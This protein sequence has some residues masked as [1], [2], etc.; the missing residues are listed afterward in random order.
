MGRNEI[1]N[2]SLFKRRDDCEDMR[3]NWFLCYGHA[4]VSDKVS[5]I[6]SKV[7]IICVERL[8]LVVKLAEHFTLQS[9]LPYAL[10][11]LWG[12]SGS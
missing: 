4:K 10:M 9:V 2:D 12:K 11:C 8:K 1:Q 5:G 6:D 3:R 7:P